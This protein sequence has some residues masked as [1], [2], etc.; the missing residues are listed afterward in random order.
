MATQPKIPTFKDSQK[1]QVKVRGLEAG[2]TLFDRLKQFKK[3]DLAFILAGLGTLFMAPLAEHFMMSPENG[4]GTLQQGW[5]AGG[6]GMFDGSGGSPYEPGTNGLAPGS[7]IGGGSDLITTLNVRDPSALVMGYGAT[8]QPPTNSVMPAKAPPTAPAA[9]S[10]SDLKDALAAS[11]RGVGAAAKAAKALLPIPK[12]SLTGVSLRGMGG[13][14]GGSSASAGGPISS[15]GLVTGKAANSG[16]LGRVRPTAGYSGVSRGTTSGGTSG[17][18]ALRKAAGDAAGSFNRGGSAAK[19]LNDAANASIGGAG[20]SLGGGGTAA[21]GSTD[22]A[23]GP[24]KNGDSKNLGDSLAFLKAKAIQEA[25]IAL[26]A[27]EQEAGDNKL[28]ALKIR[29]SAAEALGGAIATAVG[30]FITCPMQLGMTVKTCFGGSGGN[31]HCITG[32]PPNESVLDVAGAQIVPMSMCQSNQMVMPAAGAMSNPMSS[33]GMI[34]YYLMGTDLYSCPPGMPALAHNCTTGSGTKQAAATP[35]PQNGVDGL[36]GGVAGQS[37]VD[38]LGN[39]CQQID[40]TTADMEK[41]AAM[42]KVSAYLGAL[43]TSAGMLVSGR[44]AAYYGQTA[45]CAAVPL[46]PKAAGGT[47]AENIKSAVAKLGGAAAPTGPADPK[48]VIGLMKARR[49]LFQSNAVSADKFPDY[50][51]AVTSYK[52]AK[53]TLDAADAKVNGDYTASMAKAIMPTDV[54]DQ[55][56]STKLASLKT[57]LDSTQQGLLVNLKTVS[58]ANDGLRVQLNQVGSNIG[59]TAD[60]SSPAPGSPILGNL[61]QQNSDYKDEAGYYGKTGGA[62]GA[63]DGSTPSAD[64]GAASATPPAGGSATPPAGGSPSDGSAPPAKPYKDAPSTSL[65]GV[66]KQL[67]KTNPTLVEDVSKDAVKVTVSWPGDGAAPNIVSADAVVSATGQTQKSLE[68][69][70][71]D[72][73]PLATPAS[74]VIVA[75]D[76]SVTLLHQTEPTQVTADKNLTSSLADFKDATMN[77]GTMQN[78][79]A[80]W[81]D[82][83]QA[84]LPNPNSLPKPGPP[85]PAPAPAPSTGLPSSGSTPPTQAGSPPPSTAQ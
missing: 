75:A 69:L 55:N 2:V 38:N 15:N 12:I 30:G 79:E 78:S 76:T 13:I 27:K 50:D 8:Q 37:S 28:E 81:L 52:E 72:V 63:D 84:G 83:I 80:A 42:A 43:K 59:K 48:S 11:A 41:T 10:D 3:K 58:D 7:A 77:R 26:W 49:K 74:T 60:G 32:T 20:G 6:K 4:D 16:G 73:A 31:T 19:G 34:K 39:Y 70:K 33:S 64:G 71:T 45:D 57:E 51:M 23:G 35:G 25:Q 47:A 24:D 54:V 44:D 18:D 46:T 67:N 66:V 62:S 14:G 5:K 53:A 22:K 56:L 61:V 82:S 9:R 65:A 36:G 17:L 40:K 68:Q 29:N 1:P 21:G 85:S